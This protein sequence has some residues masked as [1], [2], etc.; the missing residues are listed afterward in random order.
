MLNCQTLLTRSGAE[1]SDVADKV[2]CWTVIELLTRSGAQLSAVADKVERGLPSL[3]RAN[4]RG[5]IAAQLNRSPVSAAYFTRSMEKV[6]P[7][8]RDMLNLEAMRERHLCCNTVWNFF[9][10]GFYIIYFWK[11]TIALRENVSVSI[12]MINHLNFHSLRWLIYWNLYQS[13]VRF[14]YFK[15]TSKSR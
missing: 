12:I 3:A 15:N 4:N 13:F 14:N 10:G 8:S 7:Q 6:H 2:Q 11:L 9:G 1:L 5:I